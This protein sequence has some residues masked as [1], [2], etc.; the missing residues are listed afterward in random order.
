MT[1]SSSCEPGTAGTSRDELEDALTGYAGFLAHQL[2]E[3]ALLLSAAGDGGPVAGARVRIERMLGDLRDLQPLPGE[4]RDVDLAVLAREV[5]AELG[6]PGRQAR[7]SA[8]DA[9]LAVRGDPALLRALLSHLLRAGLAAAGSGVRFTLT[10]TARADGRVDVDLLEGCAPQIAAAAERRLEPLQRPEGSGAL[11][12][13]GVSGPAAAR[14]VTA[15]GGTIAISAVDGGAVT[16]F[17][18]PGAG[19]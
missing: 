16:R 15:H 9:M 13:A 17:D 11:L 2:A 12:G 5:A 10:T 14:I 19:S 18:L 4:L 7:L 3:L 6:E 1:R 8:G